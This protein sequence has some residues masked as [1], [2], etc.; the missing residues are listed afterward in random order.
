MPDAGVL[1]VSSLATGA[2][3]LAW[4]FPGQGTQAVGMGRDL[5]E[6]FPAARHVLDLAE[7]T[8]GFPLTQLLFDGPAE[9]L[10]LTVNTQ[11]AIVAVSLAALA[12]FREAWE[13]SF[14]SPPPTPRFV[15]GHSVGEYAALVASGAASAAT[16]LRLV[17]ER[18]RLMHQAGDLHTGGMVAVLGL[19][20][21]VVEAACAT[22]RSQIPAS[23]VAV[24]NHNAPTQVTIAGDPEGLAAAQAACQA[25][26][27]RRCMPLAVSAAFHSAAMQP[28][29]GPL[30]DAV[31]R[32][33]IVD[34]SIPLVG[35]VDAH[36]LI[37][38]DDLRREL[39]E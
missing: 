39:A 25:A 29:A 26:G 5:Y 6:T 24:A 11:P 2:A 23:Y 20:R 17:Q 30:A 16:A 3:P 21:P 22:A 13:R 18:A 19:E 38:V 28:A 35:N 37:A 34:A 36:P 32:A 15:A 31:A 9:S 7:K 12:S 27:A 10:Q 8:L 33:E 1:A 14:G 4:L